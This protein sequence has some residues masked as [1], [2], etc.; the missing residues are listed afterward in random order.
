M[1]L[2]FAAFLAGVL[3][4]LL[5]GWNLLWAIFFGLGLF[6]LLGLKRGHT[7]AQLWQMAWKKGRESLIVVPVFLLIGTVTALW[8]SSGT[9]SFFLYYGLREVPPS[10]F[11]LAAFLLS[12]ILS[13]ALGTSFGVCGTAGVVLMTMARGGGVPTAM[14]AGA[15][16][17]GA[18]FGDRG[19]PMSS[20]AML[21]AASTGTELYGDVREMLR[22]AAL[23]TILTVAFYGAISVL[24]PIDKM[25]PQVLHAISTHFSLPW[26]A[27]LP[28]AFLLLLPLLRV[29]VIWAMSASALTAFL[30]SV[31]VQHLPVLTVLKT[32]LLGYV[33]AAP[34]LRGILSGGGLASMLQASLIVF[35]TSLYAGILEGIDALGPIRREADKLVKRVGL[36]PATALISAVIIGVF[37]NQ[38]VMVIMDEQLLKESYQRRGASS[39]ERAMDIA[40]SG[41]VLAGLVPWSIALT[42]PLTMLGADL[43]AVPYA[44][45]LYLIPLCYFFTRKFFVP[46]QEAGMR[47]RL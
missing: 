37:C 6:F 32:A 35:V 3:V 14:A 30:L 42:I 21:V 29:R 12:A 22:T 17:S 15:V 16:I 43:S 9:I 2:C 1:T 27:L 4:T 5:C 10:L 13:F 20:C 40:N 46:A 38:S 39:L 26:F 36:F 33:P 41:V 45:L 7:G 8:R 44:V 24:Y 28:A 47:A 25:E 31:F 19:S 34:E 18:Y 11:L 23:P